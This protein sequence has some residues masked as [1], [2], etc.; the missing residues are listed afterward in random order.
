MEIPSSR[1]HSMMGSLAREPGFPAHKHNYRSHWCLAVEVIG[2]LVPSGILLCFFFFFPL[3]LLPLLALKNPWLNVLQGVALLLRL[4]IRL[5]NAV[6]LRKGSGA[7]F[8]SPNLWKWYNCLSLPLW[9]TVYFSSAIFF[10]SYDLLHS[11]CSLFFFFVRFSL[12]TL[13]I[14]ASA[15]F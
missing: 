15:Y 3:A 2:A 8:I 7:I 9:L 10:R 12:K 11:H 1:N 13:E 6:L 14:W 5:I 4:T